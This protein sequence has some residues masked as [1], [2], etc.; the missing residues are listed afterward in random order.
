MK[1]SAPNS[2]NWLNEKYNEHTRIY[3][4]GVNKEEKVG[5]AIVANQDKRP[6][7]TRQ[8]KRPIINRITILGARIC[9]K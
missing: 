5:Y 3:P 2:K 9:C 8:V 1:Y 4:D 7:N 6:I